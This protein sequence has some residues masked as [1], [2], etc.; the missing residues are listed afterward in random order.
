MSLT[1]LHLGSW[2]NDPGRPGREA[3][4]NLAVRD[5]ASYRDRSLGKVLDEEKP[6]AV[7][8]LSTL[9]FAHRACIRYCR[10]RSIPTLLLYHGLEAAQGEFDYKV[11]HFAHGSFILSKA[12]KT[13][14]HTL[15]CYVGALTR[16]RAPIRDYFH[17]LADLLR[18]AT[19]KDVLV[20]PG[21]ARTTRC[22]VYAKADIPHAVR[23]YGYRDDEVV[24]V[25]NPDL[26][27]FGL[28]QEMVG[29][30]AR[31]SALTK[32][33]VMYIE[34]GFVSVGY[35][36][37]SVRQFADHLLMTEKR[38][39]DQ[40]M[41]ML[42]KYKPHP[43][44]HAEKLATYLRGSN[45]ELVANA[46]FLGR[47]LGCSACI[48]ETTTLAIVPAL[49]GMPLF[50]ANYGVLGELRF[51]P[52]L[53]SYPRGYVLGDVSNMADILR[54]DGKCLDHIALANWIDYN[55]GPFPADDRSIRIAE[56]V[57]ELVGHRAQSPNTGGSYPCSVLQ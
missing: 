46:D 23:K 51:G 54:R 42:F 6:D 22:C 55:A 31:C 13:I 47:L 52:A 25:G 12:R 24:A 11:N 9:T 2:G 16:T 48:V 33:E 26:M 57:E 41:K 50:F 29:S 38:L 5:I 56:V 37:S 1:L 18:M 27:R 10:Q 36:F 3:I 4:G 14:Q 21:D 7:I 49:L 44:E 53:T 43:A 8:L 19:G 39:A 35:L 45:I 34:T 17:F 30:Q 32:S 40:G 15:P 20:A 28:T